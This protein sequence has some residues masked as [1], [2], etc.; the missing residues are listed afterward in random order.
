MVAGGL[1]SG[2]STVKTVEAVE[3]LEGFRSSA[4]AVVVVVAEDCT[5]ASDTLRGC[6]FGSSEDFVTAWSRAEREG[7]F[8]RPFIEVR[9]LSCRATGG[10]GPDLDTET[11]AVFSGLGVRV[12]TADSGGS[13]R[14]LAV[15][16]TGLKA[17]GFMMP[18]VLLAGGVPCTVDSGGL[19]VFVG[20]L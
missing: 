12:P 20:T 13:T 2:E 15:L 11:S 6:R 16:E 1:I 9:G 19:Y 7:F 5:D 14:A 10:L 4:D 18:E 8:S 3:A 17:R